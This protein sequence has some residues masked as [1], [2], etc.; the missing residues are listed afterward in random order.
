MYAMSVR[1]QQL[2]II[3][4]LSVLLVLTIKDKLPRENGNSFGTLSE[5]IKGWK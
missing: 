5:L 4:K 3:K 1:S 2:K